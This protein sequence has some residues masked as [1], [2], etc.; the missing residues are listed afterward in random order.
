MWDRG[1]KGWDLRSQA[2]GSGSERD[3]IDTQLLVSR[4]Q[5]ILL[6]ENPNVS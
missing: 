3:T 4:E 6:S 1:S 5:L 2:M